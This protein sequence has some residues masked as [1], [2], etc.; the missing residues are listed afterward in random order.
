[1]LFVSLI[2]VN[3][4]KK[5]NQILEESTGIDRKQKFSE[6]SAKIQGKRKGWWKFAIGGPGMEDFGGLVSDSFSGRGIKGEQH[7][8]FFKETLEKPL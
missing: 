4:S 7:Q 3:I 2:S 8:E 6:A 5:F 1:M